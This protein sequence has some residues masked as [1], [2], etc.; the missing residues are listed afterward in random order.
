MTST[1]IDD[2]AVELSP[3]PFCGGDGILVPAPMHMI[4]D[5]TDVYVRCQACD[6]I[7]PAV[8]YERDT[9]QD[10]PHPEAIAAWNTRAPLPA[11]VEK[12]VKGERERELIEALKTIQ[13]HCYVPPGGKGNRLRFI[14]RIAADA[15]ANANAI[16]STK[17]TNTGEA[18]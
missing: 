17:P 16:Q 5:C 7:G 18:S 3:C 14:A 4:A 2:A 15:V 12:A 8:L 6:A 10:D 9:A 1:R 13:G 11:M